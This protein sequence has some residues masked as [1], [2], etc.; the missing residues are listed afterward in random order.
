MNEEP[1]ALA[2]SSFAGA[3]PAIPRDPRLLEAER[4][5][6]EARQAE[7]ELANARQ[8]ADEAAAR[9]AAAKA[10]AERSRA[11]LEVAKEEALAK[12]R[13]AALQVRM[14]QEE[15][16]RAVVESRQMARANREEQLGTVPMVAEEAEPQIITVTKR[17][18]DGFLGSLG[19]FLIRLVFAAFVGLVG[20]QALVDRPAVVEALQWVGVPP[21]WESMAAIG[22]GAGLLV[23]AFF[24][25]I[26][27]G[28]R[29]MS[30]L[31]LA[32][33][34]VFLAFFRF[35]P[36]SPL[37]EGHFGFYGDREVMVGVMCLLFLFLGAG[38]WSV[39]ASLRRHRQRAREIG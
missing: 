31:L 32:G 4:A 30:V 39:D 23:V 27:L 3:S 20:W 21:Q 38:G 15:E 14:E 6:W 25:L 28:T 17:S 26:G 18:T 29:V 37:L 19:L 10:N 16:A 9:V 2:A 5:D 22:V 13:A 11:K 34:I 1:T 8:I 35:G 12:A 7:E 36:F 24:L 33:T